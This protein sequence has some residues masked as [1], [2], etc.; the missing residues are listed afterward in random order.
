[1]ISENWDQF[2]FIQLLVM[3]SNGL[4]QFK[5]IIYWIGLF[6]DVRV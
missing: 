6:M 3:T 2:D 5:V 4:D 1:M